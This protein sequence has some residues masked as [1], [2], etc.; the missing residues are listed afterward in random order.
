MPRT[1][2]DVPALNARQRDLEQ[3]AAQTEFLYE[4][5]N[6]QKQMLLLY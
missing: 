5:Q 2:F 4:H 1:V 3:L 6:A